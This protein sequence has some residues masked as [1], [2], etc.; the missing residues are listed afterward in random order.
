MPCN[1]PL[2]AWDIGLTENGK[3]KYKITPFSVNHIE[4]RNGIWYNISEEFISPY[5]EAVRTKYVQIPCGKCIGCRLDY[6]KQW[7]NR[8]MLEAQY[9][10]EAYFVTLTYDDTH[11]PLSWYSDPETGEAK[12][13]MTLRKRDFQLF[14]KR[15]RKWQDVQ[16]VDNDNCFDSSV[17]SSQIRYFASGEY[18]SKSFRP[19]YHA[20]IFN[21]H[22]DDL[23]FYKFNVLGQPLYTSESLERVWSVK[24]SVRG[25]LPPLTSYDRIGIVVV[26][27]LSYESAAYTA[28]YTAKKNNTQGDD[29]FE[30]FNMEKPFTLMSRRPGIGRQYYDDHPEMFDYTTLNISTADGGKKVP[31]PKYFNNLFDVDEPIR[32]KELKAIRKRMAEVQAELKLERTDLDYESYLQVCENNLINKTKSSIIERSAI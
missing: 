15:L 24:S 5:H 10:N 31:I 4:K 25:V 30:T 28:R 9:H 23:V 7:A 21:L 11:V 3:T 29:F 12:Q 17:S 14:M 18:G 6:A 22:L 20:I 13:A 27:K 32:S 26:G 16:S 2:K 1:H 19:H 8:I